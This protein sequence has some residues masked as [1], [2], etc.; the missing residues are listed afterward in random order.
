MIKYILIHPVSIVPT[1][2]ITKTMHMGVKAKG[3]QGIREYAYT[4]LELLE[5]IEP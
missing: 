4:L 1:V 3:F 5:E 2:F